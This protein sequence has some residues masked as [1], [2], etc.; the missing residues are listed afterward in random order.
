MTIPADISKSAETGT[1]KQ[2][3][4]IMST[5]MTRAAADE[6]RRFFV[7]LKIYGGKLPVSIREL[8]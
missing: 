1:K 2:A 8:F 6:H 5:A 4:G 7:L 3:G